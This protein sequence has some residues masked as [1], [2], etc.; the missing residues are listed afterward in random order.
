VGEK[1][2]MYR[3]LMEKTEGKRLFGRL[4]KRKE[5]DIKTDLK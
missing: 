1:A 5:D 2:Y 3:V 4:G